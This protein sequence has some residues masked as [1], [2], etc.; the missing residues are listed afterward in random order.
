MILA[1]GL[2]MRLRPLTL[3][4]PKPLIE[5]RGRPLIV[6]A[7]EHMARAGVQ[8]IAINTHYLAKQIPE[9]LGDNYQGIPIVYLY[10]PEI[11]GT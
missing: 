10:E 5:L 1:A 7:L 9:A 8:K 2:G 4:K 6:Y 11:L 3:T